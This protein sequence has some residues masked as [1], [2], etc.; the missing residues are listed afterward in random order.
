MSDSIVLLA[1]Q[2]LTSWTLHRRHVS[3]KHSN[4]LLLLYVYDYAMLDLLNMFLSSYVLQR[5]SSHTFHSQFLQLD[6]NSGLLLWLQQLRAMLIKRVL[7]TFRY[8][9]AL[10]AQL[11]LPVFFI[12]LGLT[13]LKTVPAYTSQDPPRSLTLKES[14]PVTNIS[15][16]SAN[17][18]VYGDVWDRF[19]DVS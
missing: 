7:N 17:F 6:L 14:S 18:D 4:P 12:A 1:R 2:Y 15:I 11:L 16:F 19:F 8:P 13:F 5:D 10:V 3:T 9:G